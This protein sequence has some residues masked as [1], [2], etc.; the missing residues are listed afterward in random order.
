MNKYW[1]N[2]VDEYNSA[3]LFF[4][5]M[6]QNFLAKVISLTNL[7][8]SIEEKITSEPRNVTGLHYDIARIMRMTL[9][10]PPIEPRQDDQ[11]NR[12]LIPTDEQLND[13]DISPEDYEEH[14]TQ[15]NVAIDDESTGESSTTSLHKKSRSARRQAGLQSK[16]A[17]HPDWGFIGELVSGKSHTEKK[18]KEQK[19][20]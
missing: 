10:F 15:S 7:Y 18:I 4:L 20:A 17:G 13:P 16:K 12:Y 6:L 9:I 8:F 14:D 3:G 11:L 1:Y 2:T 19:I 5:S